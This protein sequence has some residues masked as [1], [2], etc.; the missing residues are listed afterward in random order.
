MTSVQFYTATMQE[1]IHDIGVFRRYH[2]NNNP[3]INTDPLG[4]VCGSGW[5]DWLVLDKGKYF[6]FTAACNSH[7][8][9]YDTPGSNK[10]NC[11]RKFLKNMI[12]SCKYFTN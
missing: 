3:I 10:G 2:V 12:A 8:R 11:D 9:C 6:N 5:N 7:D 4:L 1:T